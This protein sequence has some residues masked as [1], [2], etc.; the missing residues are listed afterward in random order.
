MCL[1]VCGGMGIGYV[2]RGGGG[3]CLGVGV[4]VEVWV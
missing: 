2:V 4:C 1:E 3:M